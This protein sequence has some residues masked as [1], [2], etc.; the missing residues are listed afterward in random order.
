MRKHRP[1]RNLDILALGGRNRAAGADQDARDRAFHT[2]DDAADDGA[3]AGAG[4]DTS[5]FTLDAFTLDRVDRV[6]SNL[7]GLATDHELI[8]GQGQL[9]GTLGA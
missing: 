9:A 6:G 1:F 8:E 5:D 7:I 4:R 3:H 2:A